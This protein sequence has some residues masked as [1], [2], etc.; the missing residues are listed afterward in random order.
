MMVNSLQAFW[1]PLADT[2]GTG[3]EHPSGVLKVEPSD[4]T[5]L[6]PMSSDGK[7]MG[8][9]RYPALSLRTKGRALLVQQHLDPTI[10][11]V[12]INRPTLPRYGAREV[13]GP[14]L[15]CLSTASGPPPPLCACRIRINL[16]NRDVSDPMMASFT[17][18]LSSSSINGSLG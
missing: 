8:M 10:I 17:V 11:P 6:F 7:P 18:R 12:S 3:T 15:L 2:A 5:P 9:M 16:I 1:T 14:E 13:H 4:E